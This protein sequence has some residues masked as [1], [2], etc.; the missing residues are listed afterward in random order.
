MAAK[1]IKRNPSARKAA[2]QAIKRNATNTA[3]VSALRSAVKNVETAIA[4]GVK[5][6]AQEAFKIAQPQIGRAHV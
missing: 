2:R 5:A 1:K 6:A 3:R 4:S